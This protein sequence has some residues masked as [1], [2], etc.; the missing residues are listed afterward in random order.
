MLRH[1]VSGRFV[2]IAAAAAIL[3]MFGVRA[4]ADDDAKGADVPVAK[5][6]VANPPVV[7]PPAAAKPD[8]PPDES[9]TPANPPG[10]DL[11][12]RGLTPE[13]DTSPSGRATNPTWSRNYCGCGS[14]Y[15]PTYGWAGYPGYAAPTYYAGY[16]P[17]SYYGFA[18]YAGYWTYPYYYT[19]YWSYYSP[20]AGYWYG[21][22]YGYGYGY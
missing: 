10:T 2:R 13:A 21:Y 9:V 22:G 1:M 7:N 11:P 19:P 20:F 12:G 5:P 8:L 15:Y 17:Y 6:P 18:P 3:S 14:T 16:Y 4:S